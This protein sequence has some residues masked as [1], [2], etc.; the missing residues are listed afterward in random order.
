MYSLQSLKTSEKRGL[1]ASSSI[2]FDAH[3][4]QRKKNNA[5][6]DVPVK[7]LITEGLNTQEPAS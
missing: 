2:K 1:E 5:T 6:I 4:F 7:L 3:V